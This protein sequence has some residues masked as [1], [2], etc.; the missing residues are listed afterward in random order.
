MLE[1]GLYQTLSN[2]LAASGQPW[3]ERYVPSPPRL[4]VAPRQDSRQPR[5]HTVQAAQHAH[6]HIMGE[7][8]ASIAHEICQ[9]LLGI[10]S[11][12]AASLRFLQRDTPDI[13]EAVAGLQDIRLGCERVANIVRALRALAGQSPLQFQPV[14]VDDVIRVAVAHCA[15][16]ISKHRVRS[17]LCLKADRSIT[18]DAVQLQQ[19]VLNLISNALEAMADFRPCGRVLKISSVSL[20]GGIQVCIDDNGPGIPAQKRQ[21]VLTAF[22]TTK[23]SGLGM[24]LAICNSVIQAHKGSLHVEESGS[25]GTRIRFRLPCDLTAQL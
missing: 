25:G 23:D 5:R 15:P 6:L 3:T 13:D 1:E 10:A 8:T 22:Y 11:N 14:N 7:M 9:P 16:S 20:C 24:G 17:V 21:Q 19:L 12:A 18:A 4:S 2:A